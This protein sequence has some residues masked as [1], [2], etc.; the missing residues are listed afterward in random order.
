MYFLLNLQ[1]TESD[2]TLQ[3]FRRRFGGFLAS[4]KVVKSHCKTITTRN[5]R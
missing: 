3:L 5:W 1:L 4:L 2:S